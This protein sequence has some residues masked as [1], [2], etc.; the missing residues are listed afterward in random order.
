MLRQRLGGVHELLV[1]YWL[2]CASWQEKK[3]TDIE[4]LGRKLGFYIMSF[5]LVFQSRFDSEMI[6][7]G[8]KFHNG[9]LEQMALRI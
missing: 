1:S 5:P 6:F 4:F 7:R 3:I 2:L 9:Y 8:S